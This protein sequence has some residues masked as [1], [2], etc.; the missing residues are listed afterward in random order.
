MIF[1]KIREEQVFFLG[2]NPPAP[3]PLSYSGSITKKKILCVGGIPIRKT[4][5]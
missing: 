5:F 3:S 2:Y 4:V 1:V